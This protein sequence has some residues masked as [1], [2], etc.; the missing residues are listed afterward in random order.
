MY[1]YVSREGMRGVVK[2]KGVG[3]EKK[4]KKQQQKLYL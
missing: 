2:G 3:L 4:N 1:R